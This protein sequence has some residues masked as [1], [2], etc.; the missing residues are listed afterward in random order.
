MDLTR[1]DGGMPMERPIEL[2]ILY[3]PSTNQ[4]KIS[5]PHDNATIF[6]AMLEMAK[7]NLYE[8]RARKKRAGT[9]LIQVPNLRVPQV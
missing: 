9:S 7:V 2:Q 5:G 3:Y 4:F 6:L 1:K 8:Y